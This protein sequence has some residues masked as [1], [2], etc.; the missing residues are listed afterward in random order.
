VTLAMLGLPIALVLTCVLELMPDGVRGTR[1]ATAGCGDPAPPRDSAAA[2]SPSS[3]C[4]R[5]APERV[6]LQLDLL[7]ASGM[8][9]AGPEARA[10]GL[11]RI[12]KRTAA[13]AGP[14]SGLATPA[15]PVS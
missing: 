10:A 6:R 5:L 3:R 14:D 1:S 9:D 7:T 8:D 2:P 11:E 15:S 4:H 12:A 13:W